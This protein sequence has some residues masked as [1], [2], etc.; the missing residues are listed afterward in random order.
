MLVLCC[1]Q[2][3]CRFCEKH[4]DVNKAAFEDPRLELIY[5]D[6]R[7]QLEKWPH[8]FDVIIGDLADPLEAGPC[9]Q[10]YTLEFYTD[11]VLPKLNPGRLVKIYF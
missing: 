1:V 8:G 6:A 10:L 2:A 3:V 4:L 9:Y 5:D 11:V 7:A